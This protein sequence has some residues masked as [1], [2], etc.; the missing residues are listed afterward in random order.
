MRIYI[1]AFVTVLI[2][3]AANA[4]H[5]QTIQAGVKGGIDFS[6]LPNAGE[7]ID[8][9]VKLGSTE[10]SSKVGVVFGGFVMFPITDR[11]AFQ[12]ELAFV[13]K[14]VK[15]NEGSGGTVTAS[16]R[17]LEFPML[18]RYAMAVGTHTGYLLVGPTFGVKA[19]TSARLDGPN[20]TI[21]ENIDAAIRTFDA[22]IAFGGGID[23]GRYL[24]EARYT[25]GLIDIGTDLFP[26]PDALKNRSF[27]ILAGVRFK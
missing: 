19:G 15:L 23:Y 2:V 7:V 6:S 9:I 27:A 12:P 4:S 1:C 10:T 14:G 21:D 22:A 24:F 5:A 13:M 3:L 25:Q 16:L 18:I 26:H 8:Q 17:Y 20:Q 11:L